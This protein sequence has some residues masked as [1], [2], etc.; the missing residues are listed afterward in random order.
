MEVAG[1]KLAAVQTDGTNVSVVFPHDS[2]NLAV[3]RFYEKAKNKWLLSSVPTPFK[4]PVPTNNTKPDKIGLDYSHPDPFA[5]NSSNAGTVPLGIAS[6][7]D[8]VLS[9]FYIGIDKKLHEITET[10]DG[11]WRVAN[12]SEDQDWPEAGDDPDIAVISPMGE[13]DV[14]I[15]YQSDHE[16]VQLH[17]KNGTWM[18]PAN[19]STK[20]GNSGGSH[21]HNMSNKHDDAALTTGAKAGIGAGI[22]AGALLGGA[23]LFLV[24]RRRK[25]AAETEEKPPAYQNQ[26]QELPS[27]ADPAFELVGDTPM[28]SQQ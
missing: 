23:V 24:F 6:D 12:G 21:G 28:A 5:I 9:I 14:W 22:A 3:A 10:D 1:M 18:K 16:V 27:N 8:H 17:K 20:G 13:E 25:K 2:K 7:P 4:D 19:V 26:P 11:Q 15:F